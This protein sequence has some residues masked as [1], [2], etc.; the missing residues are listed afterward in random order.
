MS[1]GVEFTSHPSPPRLERFVRILRE[2]AIWAWVPM[3]GVVFGAWLQSAL[4]NM[5][6]TTRFAWYLAAVLATL[7]VYYTTSL[8]MRRR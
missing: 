6:E 1:S 5:T 2:Y 3:L 4:G 7:A 8:S